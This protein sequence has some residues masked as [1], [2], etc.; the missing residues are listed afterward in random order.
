MR[1]LTTKGFTAKQK[2]DAALAYATWLDYK[3]ATDTALDMYNWGLD[4]ALGPSASSDNVLDRGTVTI[5]PSSGPV[6]DNVLQAT[7]ALAIHHAR[8]SDLSKAL[9]TF[10]S[11]LRARRELADEVPTMFPN[12]TEDSE[13]PQKTRLSKFLSL[14]QGTL[15]PPKYPPPPADGTS[16][17]VRDAKERCE[18][19]A[20][21]TYIGEILYASNTGR[22]SREDGL[23]WTRESVDIAEEQLLR[24]QLRKDAKTTCRECLKAGLNNWATMVTQLTKD[25][26]EQ[27]INA[28]STKVGGWLGFGSEDQPKVLGRWESEENVVLERTRRAKDLLVVPP[29]QRGLGLFFV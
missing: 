6:S 29:P 15:A 25:E 14:L 10:L 20:L 18:E 7:T 8:N 5:K 13:E 21:M 1:V 19:A 22:S 28:P 4:I 27:K 11:V 9:P 12:L 24:R 23:A 17:P 26:K 2:L 16:A 3:G